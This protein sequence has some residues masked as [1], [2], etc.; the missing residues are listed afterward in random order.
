LAKPSLRK[1]L[2]SSAAGSHGWLMYVKDQ[3]AVEN[4]PIVTAILERF[5]RFVKAFRRSGLRKK[6]GG[7]GNF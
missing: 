2:L 3:S 4:A 5:C 7:Q 6:R 1:A